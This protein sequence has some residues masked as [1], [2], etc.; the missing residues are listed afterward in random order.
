MER[1]SQARLVIRTTQE[2]AAILRTVRE[3]AFQILKE[4]GLLP[5]RPSGTNIT[6]AQTSGAT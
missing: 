4:Q 5:E 3:L 1:L 6:S 2:E